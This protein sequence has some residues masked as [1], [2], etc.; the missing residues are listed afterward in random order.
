MRVRFRLNQLLTRQ[1][2]TG[3][4][5]ITL[6]SD[7]TGIERHKVSKLL[8]DGED[9]I[10]LR[11]LGELCRFLIQQCGIDPRELPA[12]LFELEPSRLL[13]LLRST[14][15]LR[16]CF[17]VRQRRHHTQA[18]WAA[19]ADSY[20]HG[21]MLE[22]LLRPEIQVRCPPSA[23]T[24]RTGADERPETPEEEV[25][26]LH[27]E[28]GHFHQEQVHAASAALLEDPA[29]REEELK[30]LKQDAERVYQILHDPVGNSAAAKRAQMV[31]HVALILGS[32]KSNPV[33]ELST[34][35]IFRG[36]PWEIHGRPLN[37]DSTAPATTD[38][39]KSPSDRAVP[40][41][42][43]YR[44]GANS[45]LKDPQIPSCYAGV[46]LA[47]S[48]VKCG[49]NAVTAGIYYET[50]GKLWECVPC[51]D[52]EDAAIVLF[53]HDRLLGNVE[54]VMGGFSSM[55]TLLLGTSLEQIADQFFPPP[56]QTD[57][58]A[59]GAFIVRFEIAPAE[60]SDD[61]RSARLPQV[62]R[63]PTVIPLAAEVL[64][65]RLLV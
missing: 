41:F 62:A 51:S 2:V 3:H 23:A 38:L 9:K 17:G 34:A 60:P 27:S 10:S 45:A 20:L 50:P 42:I 37:A 1:G 21:K 16:S 13:A 61:A 22:L 48:R 12:A 4:G 32:V 56:F 11:H 31:R 26:T 7:A 64:E 57:N 33:C 6:I 39:V 15:T 35:R 54:V 43:R 49:N 29:E 53:D 59:V 58:R 44:D 30:F 5:R 28:I 55:A 40:F 46:R 63:A 36:I 19:G 18:P 25:L 52:T 8:D 47:Q 24:S 65:R 14:P